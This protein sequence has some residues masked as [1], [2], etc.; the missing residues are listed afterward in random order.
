[1]STNAKTIVQNPIENATKSVADSMAE[2]R[3]GL[4]NLDLQITDFKVGWIKW[5]FIIWILQ[6][7]SYIF[8]VKFFSH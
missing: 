2:V 5:M 3:E 1:M 6:L 7:V 8:I 4:A